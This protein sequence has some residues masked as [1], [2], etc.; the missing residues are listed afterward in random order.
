MFTNLPMIVYG[1]WGVYT[2]L[3]LVYSVAYIRWTVKCGDWYSKMETGNPKSS[4][5]VTKQIVSSARFIEFFRYATLISF[6]VS[7]MVNILAVESGH[8]TLILVLI[9]MPW[10]ITGICNIF[11]GRQ[12]SHR[13]AYPRTLQPRK[14]SITANFR[15][16]GYDN[17][18]FKIE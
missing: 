12:A 10:V 11:I 9:A 14:L 17:G 1:L 16:E 6:G 7:I 4:V 2:L 5:R 3:A 8:L 15:Q 13:D 18:A